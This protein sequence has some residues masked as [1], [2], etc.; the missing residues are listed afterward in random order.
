MANIQSP[1]AS[2]NPNINTKNGGLSI[3]GITYGTTSDPKNNCPRPIDKSESL[4]N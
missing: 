2:N 4:S 1:T 3:D